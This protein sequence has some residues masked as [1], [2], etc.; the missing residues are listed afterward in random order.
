MVPKSM[1]KENR[2][3]FSD[4]KV[5]PTG[6]KSNANPTNETRIMLNTTLKTPVSSQPVWPW[7]SNPNVFGRNKAFIKAYPGK[8]K[9]KSNPEKFLRRLSEFWKTKTVVIL[10]TARIRVIM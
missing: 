8:P 3:R 1:V 6:L 2:L 9:V 4:V 5:T 7:R 10:A